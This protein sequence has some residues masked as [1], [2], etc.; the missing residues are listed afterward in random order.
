MGE[1]KR[2]IEASDP[3]WGRPESLYKWRMRERGIKVV[4]KHLT[5]PQ[6]DKYVA[7][8]L[9]PRSGWLKGAI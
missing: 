2:R 9:P 7:I 5:S 1:A 6:S 3:T 8:P 4:A